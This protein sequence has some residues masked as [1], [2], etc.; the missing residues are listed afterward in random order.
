M[1][2]DYEVSSKP[3]E[4]QT[5]PSLGSMNAL[6]KFLTGFVVVLLASVIF[7]GIRYVNLM[8]QYE[9]VKAQTDSYVLNDKVL[10]FSD[11]FINKVLKSDTEVSFEDRL[12]LENSVR[13]LND[14]ELFGWWNSFV[15]AKTEEQAQTAVKNLL[16][17][18]IKKIQTE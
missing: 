10:A 18:L 5:T 13:E 15:Q 6:E 8:R 7:L 14:P 1:G 17:T 2:M 16:A 4:S 9:E 12:H 3:V 11:L